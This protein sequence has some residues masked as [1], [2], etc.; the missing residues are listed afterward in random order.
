MYVMDEMSMIGRQMLG[1]IEY[2]QRDVMG[3]A[4]GAD[5]GEV[6]LNG[7]DA[8]MAG[9]PKQCQPIGDEPLYREGEYCKKGVNKK[10]GKTTNFVF[11]RGAW[12]P[13]EGLGG[14]FVPAWAGGPRR[15][16]RNVRKMNA[17]QPK[18]IDF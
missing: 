9:D 12:N 5:G 16:M 2:R 17:N 3:D 18:T 6:Y 15:I 7:R 11:K 13:P 1:K 14:T 10:Q 8:V 4:P